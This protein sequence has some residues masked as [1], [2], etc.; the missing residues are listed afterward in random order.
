MS[1]TKAEKERLANAERRLGVAMA[2]HWPID[3]KP[4]PVDVQK[5]LKGAEYGTLYVGWWIN[6][7][8]S[9]SWCVR[10]AIGQGCSNGTNH[11]SSSTTKTSTQGPGCFYATETEALLALR[12]ELC[13]EFAKKL[14]ALDVRY[15]EVMK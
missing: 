7:Y 11:S 2:L 5:E 12:W 13:E 8:A 6:S 15:L 3:P 14:A 9:W 10:D 1:M 4:E